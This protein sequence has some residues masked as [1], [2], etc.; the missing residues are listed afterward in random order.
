MEWSPELLT[1]KRVGNS[2]SR[3]HRPNSKKILAR[4]FNYH[5]NT[6]YTINGE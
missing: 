4:R 3:K 1:I 2:L 6:D 5:H